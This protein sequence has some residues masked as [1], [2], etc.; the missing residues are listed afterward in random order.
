M[1]LTLKIRRIKGR[2]LLSF[3]I[4]LVLPHISIAE[5]VLFDDS[6]QNGT[7]LWSTSS[8]ESSLTQIGEPV[9]DGDKKEHQRGSACE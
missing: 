9:A 7:F 8:S 4:L 6:P 1:K 5:T 3:Y 2:F